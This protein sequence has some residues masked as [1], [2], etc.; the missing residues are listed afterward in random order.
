MTTVAVGDAA[1][2]SADRARASYGASRRR[3]S[4]RGRRGSGCIPDR[5]SS[6]GDFIPASASG[7]YC[8]SLQSFQAMG[9]GH[10]IFFGVGGRRWIDGG[11][12]RR[13]RPE[14]SGSTGSLDLNVI[15]NFFRGPL[16]KMAGTAVHVSSF[17]VSVFLRVFVCFSYPV[18]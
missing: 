7:V 8:G 15:G 11:G 5:C 2:W 1:S 4:I 6:N 10:G 12:R 13:R 16:C 14:L 17:S 9:L 3:A 18:I